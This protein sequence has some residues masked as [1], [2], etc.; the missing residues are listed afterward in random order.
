MND[1]TGKIV[2]EGSSTTEAIQTKKYFVAPDGTKK[3]LITEDLKKI[4]AED[5]NKL[6][7]SLSR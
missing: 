4:T 2:G 1:G 6:L 5:Y 7:A 3:V